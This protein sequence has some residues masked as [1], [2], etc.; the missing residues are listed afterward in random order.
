MN[1]NKFK[2]KLV[3]ENKLAVPLRTSTKQ[4]IKSDNLCCEMEGVRTPRSHAYALAMTCAESWQPGKQTEG[5]FSMEDMKHRLHAA[6]C[7]M[8]GA[9]GFSEEAAVMEKERQTKS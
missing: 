2:T 9:P 3:T 8:K 1:N 4:Q 5:H 6:L 7:S